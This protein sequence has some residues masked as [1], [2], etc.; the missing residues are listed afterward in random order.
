MRIFVGNLNDK[1]TSFHLTRLFITYG[2]VISAHIMPDGTDGHS[3]GF[4]I[5][6]MEDNN[7]A[8][9]IQGLDSSRFMNRYMEV[10]EV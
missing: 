5:V 6:E 10:Y 3:L 8:M 1:V 2:K 4:G 7:A 9:A